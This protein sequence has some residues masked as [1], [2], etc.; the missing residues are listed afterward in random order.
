MDRDGDRVLV[1]LNAAGLGFEGLVEQFLPVI[2]FHGRVLSRQ[3]CAG[4]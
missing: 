3:A 4:S 2:G 1:D